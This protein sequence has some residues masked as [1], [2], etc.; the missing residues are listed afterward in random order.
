MI[1]A[2]C[3]PRSDSQPVLTSFIYFCHL[4]LDQPVVKDLLKKKVRKEREK[5]QIFNL[6]VKIALE[7]SADMRPGGTMR[8]SNPL[9]SSLMRSLRTDRKHVR[10][11]LSHIMEMDLPLLRLSVSSSHIF[12]SKVKWC[13]R[14]DA[15]SRT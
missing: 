9:T 13:F 15:H 12:E 10:C 6:T 11:Y 14:A 1:A 8:L 2:L 4:G 5:R 3:L 7:M